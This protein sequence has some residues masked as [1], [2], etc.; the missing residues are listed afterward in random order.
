MRYSITAS[1]GARSK[2]LHRRQDSAEL[3]SQETGYFYSIELEIGTPPQAVSVNFDTGSSEL[4]VN[5]ECSKATDPA[6]CQSFGRYNASKTFVDTKADGGI[7]YGTGYVDFTYGYDYVQLGCKFMHG[8][9][10]FLP[11]RKELLCEGE[12]E[13]RPRDISYPTTRSK[14]TKRRAFWTR[15]MEYAGEKKTF[16]NSQYSFQNQPAAF[17]CCD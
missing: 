7:K 12:D 1:K 9:Q 5:P 11:L 14:A 3:Q 6:F 13:R 17:R 2:H 16:A 4:W 15:T 8:F 10:F